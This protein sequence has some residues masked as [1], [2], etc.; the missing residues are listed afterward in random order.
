MTTISLA[1]ARCPSSAT[2]SEECVIDINLIIKMM[3]KLLHNK[4]NIHTLHFRSFSVKPPKPAAGFKLPKLKEEEQIVGFRPQGNSD[5]FSKPK[6]F[7]FEQQRVNTE[8]LRFNIV[9]GLIVLSLIP[10]YMFVKN[11][12]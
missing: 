9:K 2:R 8:Q 11:A 10:I 3:L 6:N 7:N 12:E 5:L 1:T 4:P